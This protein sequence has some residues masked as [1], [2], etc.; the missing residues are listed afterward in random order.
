[1][2]PPMMSLKQPRR[3]TLS[4]RSGKFPLSYTASGP[5][6]T[7]SLEEVHIHSLEHGPI[8]VDSS[9]FGG[10]DLNGIAHK[11]GSPSKR[12]S[13]ISTLDH[14]SP[15]VQTLDNPIQGIY[16]HGIQSSAR[17]GSLYQL[18]DAVAVEEVSPIPT[19]D[20]GGRA[21]HRSH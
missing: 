8:A 3:L 13:T 7:T 11:L 5:P 16:S 6:Q 10:A 21:A 12:P 17:L 9:R 20:R 15:P 19:P 4:L 18:D 14:E 1:M 2:H